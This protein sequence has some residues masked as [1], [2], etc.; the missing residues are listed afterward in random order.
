MGFKAGNQSIGGDSAVMRLTRNAS[1]DINAYPMSGNATKSWRVTFTPTK[2]Q[3][4]YA[5]LT[6]ALTIV[7]ADSSEQWTYYPDAAHTTA[8]AKAWIFM[9]QSSYSAETVTV[10]F[11]VTCPD[12][13]TLTV[14]GL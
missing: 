8:T 2:M 13:G 5:E 6:Y 4:A 7:T 11:S 10:Q 3:D 9:F 14:V 12:T 1:P